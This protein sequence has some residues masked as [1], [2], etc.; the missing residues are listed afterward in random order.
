[1]NE[2]RKLAREDPGLAIIVEV[3]LGQGTLEEKAIEIAREIGEKLE[4]EDFAL[5]PWKDVDGG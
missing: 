5:V 4:K 3:L 2:L 1:M